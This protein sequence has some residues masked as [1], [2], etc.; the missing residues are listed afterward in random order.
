MFTRVPWFW[1]MATW[2]YVRWATVE[3]KPPGCR[4]LW[5]SPSLVKASEDSVKI[6]EKTSPDDPCI[7]YLPQFGSFI[8]IYGVNVGRY[9]IHGWSGICDFFTKQHL[10]PSL[11]QLGLERIFISILHKNQKYN[12]Q[13]CRYHQIPQ[14]HGLHWYK[15][16]SNIH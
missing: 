14:N 16:H 5:T 2:E 11:V 7:V 1:P 15:L 13:C 9:S 6:E 12:Q 10:V 8:F 3:W 4:Q